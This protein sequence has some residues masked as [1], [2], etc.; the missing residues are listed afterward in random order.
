MLER[1]DKQGCLDYKNDQT[2]IV[3]KNVA[4]LF[5][6]KGIIHKLEDDYAYD[7]VLI[8]VNNRNRRTYEFRMSMEVV[9][10]PSGLLAEL[11]KNKL[12][13]DPDWERPIRKHIIYGYEQCDAAG[14][15]SYKHDVLGWHPVNNQMVYFYDS[16]DFN[17]YHSETTR[18]R[19]QFR[20]GSK[21]EFDAMLESTVF[22]SVE[23]SLAL[24][25]GYSAVLS[26]R[27]RYKYSL[28][29]I[30][31]N[32]CGT[33]SIGKSTA[34]MLMIAPFTRPEI[35]NQETGS[36]MTSL[37]TENALYAKI[38]GIHGV[39]FVVDDITTNSNL[40]FADFVYALSTCNPKA[41]CNGDGTS[42]FA[43]FG[44][45][46]VAIT[47][48]ED[49]ILNHAIAHG[50]LKVRVLQ[51]EGI[52]WTSNADDAELISSTVLEN[53]GFGGKEFG[54]YV[55]QI[56]FDEL[57]ERYEASREVVDE[58]MKKK[59]GFSSRLKNKYAV[60]HATAGLLN[61]AFGYPISADAVTERIIRCEQETIAERDIALK[62]LDLVMEFVVQKQA[63]FDVETR[64]ESA[65]IYN[66]TY[67][68]G[69]FY[70]KIFKF[71]DSWEVYMLTSK[72]VQVLRNG[73]IPHPNSIRK[74]WVERNITK[75]D[76]DHNSKQRLY[77]GKKLRYDC[78]TIPGGIA[79]PTSEMPST[80]KDPIP[81]QDTPVS[82]YSVDDGAQIDAIFGGND[83][84]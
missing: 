65:K 33:S 47:S 36:A 3:I 37:A 52:Q 9:Y 10:Q 71:D 19:Y 50:G 7:D 61:E 70:G 59:D 57:C 54:E 14:A 67:A 39:P 28:G 30:V 35:S 31:L 13:I 24:T 26:S 62:A 68:D 27:L 43:G 11:A 73:G 84:N 42:K 55:S 74:M 75:G 82:D 22:P 16:T 15:I 56:P 79:S 60:I 34:E 64:M 40:N 66:D 78:F 21:E 12:I 46:G 18:T 45:S 44:W 48:S 23:L 49:P 29:T 80:P 25:I 69:E 5:Y 58:L 83:E 41:R 72:T 76:S 32:L 38:N 63:H 8:Y 81:L 17:G 6:V 77:T 20:S 1:N 53:Y 51:T 4:P 2:G